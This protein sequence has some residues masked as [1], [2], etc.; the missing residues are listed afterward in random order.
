[1]ANIIELVDSLLP[2]DKIDIFYLELPDGK[3]GMLIEE[4]GVNGTITSFD[5]Y[6]GEI[7][8]RIQF[9]VR[10]DKKTIK[11]KYMDMLIKDFYK[12]VQ[13]NVGCEKDN[14]K[15]LYVGEFTYTPNMR[16][17]KGNYIFSLIFPVIYKENKE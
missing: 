4:T 2:Q 14:I 16:D 11:Y 3:S 17:E 6:K 12:V 9:Y 10:A 8:S 15:L 13:S 7:S 5:G 1:M